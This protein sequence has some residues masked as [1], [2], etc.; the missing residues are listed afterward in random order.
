MPRKSKGSKS[1]AGRIRYRSAI[2]GRFVSK[3]HAK[4]NPKTTVKDSRAAKFA[5]NY[6]KEHP[7]TFHELSK[8]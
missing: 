7:D 6:I 3:A 1:S 4:R 2:T 8:R 5:H